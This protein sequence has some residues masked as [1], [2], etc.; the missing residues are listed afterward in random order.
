M[1]LFGSQEISKSILLFLWFGPQNGLKTKSILAARNIIGNSACVKCNGGQEDTEHLLIHCPSSMIWA[2]ISSKLKCSFYQSS[3]LA[4]FLKLFLLSCN[5]KSND[6]STLAKKEM[7]EFLEERNGLK[8]K[9]NFSQIFCCLCAVEPLPKPF[10]QPRFRGRLGS[11][12]DCS[13]E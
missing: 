5:S 10:G 4:A 12:S 7:L 1:T 13:K 11:S 3:G 6:D 9:G 2:R 8:G